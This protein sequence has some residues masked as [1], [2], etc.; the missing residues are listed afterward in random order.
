MYKVIVLICV[1]I[2]S[3]IAILN[4]IN[5]K[6]QKPNVEAIELQ[7]QLDY[8]MSKKN[9]LMLIILEQRKKKPN[10]DLLDSLDISYYLD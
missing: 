7:N 9:T 8:V 3:T 2:G 5:S 6:D 1:L 10:K 4:Y